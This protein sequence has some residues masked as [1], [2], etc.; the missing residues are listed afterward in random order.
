MTWKV[1]YGSY[2]NPYNMAHIIL[3]HMISGNNDISQIFCYHMGSNKLVYLI[4]TRV[5]CIY[6]SI[7]SICFSDKV[8]FDRDF[9]FILVTNTI[10]NIQ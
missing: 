5:K 3:G 10:V 4:F 7:N 8:L 2:E 9:N 1:S 6:D